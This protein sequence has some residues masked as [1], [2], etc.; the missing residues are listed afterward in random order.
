MKLRKI[1][2][3]SADFLKSSNKYRLGF[4]L[5]ELIVVVTILAVLATIGFVSYSSY[6]TWVRDTNRISQLVSISDW[7]E[8]Y[9]TKNILPLPDDNVEVKKWAETIAYQGYAG[10][11]TLE[12][13][14][15]S[16][17]WVDPK[18]WEYFSYY[19]TR[20][21]KYFQLMAFLEEDEA[22]L[23][24][25]LLKNT[26]AVNYSNRVPT[27]T[28]RKLWILT[29]INNTPIQEIPSVVDNWLLNIDVTEDTSQY[30]AHI[31]DSKTIEGTISDSPLQHLASIAGVWGSISK[32]CKDL[33]EKNPALLGANGGYVLNPT[34]KKEVLAYCDLTIDSG[35][36]TLIGIS[37]GN[38]PPEE[39]LDSYIG[40]APN[41]L[42]PGSLY[43]TDAS[44]F[45][46]TEVIMWVDGDSEKY[47]WFYTPEEFEHERAFEPAP[48]GPETC[49]KIYGYYTY[50]SGS[51][52]Y[53]RESFWFY[54]TLISNRR[55]HSS[56]WIDLAT[57]STCSSSSNSIALYRVNNWHG[58]SAWNMWAASSWVWDSM[59]WSTPEPNT[60][61]LNDTHYPV[62]WRDRDVWVMIR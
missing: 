62:K 4:T 15:F 18:D 59:A 38:Y 39:F 5:V 31:N 17:W 6:L 54:E 13:I 19:L 48:S 55:D 57:T 30:V 41:N 9:R 34:G 49:G 25:W 20:D 28:W 47:F 16:K 52:K 3:H 24:S 29:D 56:W 23:T 60:S 61:S 33:L 50:D 27:V 35:G 36:W 44:D 42:E 58:A 11:N 53:N 12:I 40:S 10:A 37:N 51:T 1:K 7:L 22:N 26:L 43:S 32:N 8:L 2:G 46:F 45:T 14:D 21:K